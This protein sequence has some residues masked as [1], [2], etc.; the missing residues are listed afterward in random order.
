VL[1][2]IQGERPDLR[3]RTDRG[4]DR[5]SRPTIFQRL[6]GAAGR[7]SGE[8]KRASPMAPRGCLVRQG[9]FIQPFFVASGKPTAG[10]RGNSS[11]RFARRLELFFVDLADSDLDALRLSNN[12]PASVAALGASEVINERRILKAHSSPH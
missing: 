8:R 3:G 12:K 4:S 11:A 10:K 2:G 1:S 9:R 6:D 7:T 5:P